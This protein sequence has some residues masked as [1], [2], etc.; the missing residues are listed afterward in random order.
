M[1]N[2]N[3]AWYRLITCLVA[4]LWSAVFPAHVAAEPA[5]A[6][7]RFVVGFAQDTM[8]NDWRVAQVREVERALSAHPDIRFVYTDARGSTA[9]QILDIEDLIASG[10]DVLVTSPVDATALTPVIAKAYRQGI[11]VVLLSRRINSDD[12]TIF[13]GADDRH[14]A[15]QAAH[16]ISRYRGNGARV[17]MLKGVPK[18]TTTFDRTQSF[19]AAIQALPGLHIVAEKTANYL[20]SDAIRAM[21]AV[22]EEKLA[23]DV[24]FAQ[25]DS[26]ASGARIALKAH[27]V[28]LQRIMIVGIDYI[29]EA[30][31]AIENGE[32]QASF[33]YPTGG[34]EGAQAIINILQNKPVPKRIVLES[35]MVTKDNVAAV[36]PIF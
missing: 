19:R 35:T 25:S 36:Q 9:R 32:Q 7:A 12:Y 22:L 13:I 29:D 6:Q 10:V 5:A 11:P 34:R 18:A 15:R 26:M 2:N 24:I 27:G 8:S 20:R 16:Y 4:V 30:R 28:D 23:F 1:N 33:T 21:E 31:A 14:I 3:N 17:V